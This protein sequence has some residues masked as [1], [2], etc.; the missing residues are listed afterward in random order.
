M[1][2][3]FLT[4]ILTVLALTG[5]ALAGGEPDGSL[6]TWVDGEYLLY[7]LSPAPLSATAADHGAF[8]QIR[9]GAGSGILGNPGTQV[10]AGDQTFNNSPF[11]GFRINAGWIKCDDSFGVEVV[12][13]TSPSCRHRTLTSAPMPRAIPYLPGRSLTPAPARRP[14]CSF[15]P[16]MP[17]AAR[18]ILVPRPRCSAAMPISYGRSAAVAATMIL[19]VTS[20]FCLVFVTSTCATI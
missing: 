11:N 10:L 13:S 5:S 19:F 17:S 6:R 3:G 9:T 12:S 16:P 2:K 14:P 8:D 20:I 4:A 7:F 1:N 15:R 18:P